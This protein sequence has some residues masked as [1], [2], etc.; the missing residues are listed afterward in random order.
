M[1]AILE[2]LFKCVCNPSKTEDDD[3]RSNHLEEQWRDIRREL[4]RKDSK[5]SDIIREVD[6]N[7]DAIQRMEIKIS[8]D[9]KRLEDIIDMRIDLLNSK[10]DNVLMIL[11]RVNSPPIIYNR[12]NRIDE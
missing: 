6:N 11:N 12:L 5:L 9:T 7:K 3:D 1:V 10:I 8:N 4:Q 2:N